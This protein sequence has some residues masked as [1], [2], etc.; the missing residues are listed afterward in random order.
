VVGTTNLKP[1][2]QVALLGPIN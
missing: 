1:W 2:C